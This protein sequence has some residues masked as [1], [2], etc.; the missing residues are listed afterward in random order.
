MLFSFLSPLNIDEQPTT[1]RRNGTIQKPERH[2]KSLMANNMAAL[3]VTVCSFRVTMVMKTL[4]LIG[5]AASATV[6]STEVNGSFER[7]ILLAP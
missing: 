2:V 1:Q 7:K 4:Y 6:S 3:G 5:S